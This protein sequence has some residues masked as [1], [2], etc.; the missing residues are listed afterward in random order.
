M[1]ALAVT[2][3][4]LVPSVAHAGYWRTATDSDVE[5]LREDFRQQAAQEGFSEDIADALVHRT[6]GTITNDTGCPG[7]DVDVVNATDD[8]YWSVVVSIVQDLSGQNSSAT[9]HLPFV[10]AHSEVRVQVPCLQDSTYSYGYDPL[11]ATPITVT[12]SAEGS[13]AL[14]ADTLAAMFD[15]TVDYRADDYGSGLVQAGYTSQTLFTA[16]LAYADSADVAVPLVHAAMQ[17][18]RAV[19]GILDAVRSDPASAVA[20][21]AAAE[22]KKLKPKTA[23]P[24]VDAMIGVEQADQYADS[25]EPVIKAQCKDKHRAVALWRRAV[26]AADDAVPGYTTR[27][28][29]LH[30][31]EPNPKDVE[32]LVDDLAGDPAR[33]A[34]AVDGMP[35]KMFD[36]LF[37]RMTTKARDSLPELMRVTADGGHFDR[38]AGALRD[39]ELITAVPVV[40]RAPASPLA[41]KKAEWVKGAYG[42]AKSGDSGSQMLGAMFT[43]LANGGVAPEMAALIQSLRA[44]DPATADAALVAVIEPRVNVLL[45]AKVVEQGQDVLAFD[46]LSADKLGNCTADLDALRACAEAISAYDGGALKQV[47]AAG[48]WQPGFVDSANALLSAG[49]ATAAAVDAAQALSDIGFDLH[50]M[51][52][53]LC[54]AAKSAESRHASTSE[55]LSAIAT[56]DSGNACASAIL[57]QQHSREQKQFLFSILGTLALLVPIP[58]TALV[59]KKK[60]KKLLDD[61]K[62]PAKKDAAGGASAAAT[63]LARV[64]RHVLAGIAEAKRVLPRDS[65]PAARALEQASASEAALAARARKAAEDALASGDVSSAIVKLGDVAV[66]VAAFP[67]LHDQP[68]AIRRHLGAAWPEHAEAMRRAVAGASGPQ[69]LLSLLVFVA[70]DATEA[71]LLV[72]FTDGRVAIAPAAL[73][74]AR[75]QGTTTDFRY[76]AQL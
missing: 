62:E 17:D 3:A 21:A 12:H 9:F 24:F 33:L 28:T 32:V 72:G 64:D 56:I 41:Q 47:G 63:R 50:P 76:G 68:Q 45:A 53:Q 19:S 25:L 6:I 52:G 67:G 59:L 35:E 10:P 22:I 69:Q 44:D 60:Y 38:A 57:D 71:V 26:S 48:G 42:K 61:T 70:P 75:A 11:A 15:Q 37:D 66:Y 30:L 8:V 1:R 29:I 5:S 36:P 49:G 31:C 18:P 43:G 55:Y 39:A 34:E 14:D 74:D 13:E 20:Q 4:L 16:A 7:V 2:L 58:A 46:R 51:I 65:A 27:T 40:A 23:G 73:V 54:S